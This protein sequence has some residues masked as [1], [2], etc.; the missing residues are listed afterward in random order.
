MKRTI[1]LRSTKGTSIVLFA[2]SLVVLIGF[3]SIAVDLGLAMN[4]KA[5]LVNATDAAALAGAQELVY[6]RP[7]ADCVA[8]EYLQKNGV[9]INNAEVIVSADGKSI[10]VKT[11]KTIDYFFAK[12]LGISNGNV[13]A[14]AVAK[15]TPVTGVSSGV[16]P[17]AIENQTLVFGQRYTLKEGAGSG[18]G[19]NYGALALGGNGA[20]N[21]RGNIIHGYNGHL[22]V[23]DEVDTEPGNMRGPT[24]YGVQTL[25]NHC[26]HSPRC[27]FDNFQPDCP[28]IITVIIVDSLEVHGRS[29][30]KIV[31]FASFFL[32]DVDVDGGHTK[33]TGRFV[34]TVT[35][36][37]TSDVQADYG[38]RSVRLVN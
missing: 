24:E 19:G 6:D 34:K 33:I 21:Y 37:E 9:D 31:G 3:A 2:A 11:E 36:G 8:K 25:I 22:G 4:E 38:L 18:G 30:V 10:N 20:N 7:N 29:S 1:D 14:Y 15:A 32:E 26:N 16:R 17:F 13:G 12:V 27:T 28:R 23:G 35:S 5:V